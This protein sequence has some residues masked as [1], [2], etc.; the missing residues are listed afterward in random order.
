[1][2]AGRGRGGTY[3]V[4]KARGSLAGPRPNCVLSSFCSVLSAATGNESSS[5]EGSNG[6]GFTI[7]DLKRQAAPRKAQVLKLRNRLLG[8]HAV[9]QPA[10]PIISW[11]LKKKI[12]K[13]PGKANT[14]TR[15]SDSAL[16][17]DDAIV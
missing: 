8:R 5:D 9:L 7:A 15:R 1:M 17:I 6:K 12:R 16:S 13:V 3:G 2:R 4:T 14:P 10:L 11:S